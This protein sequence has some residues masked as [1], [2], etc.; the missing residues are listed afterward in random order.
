MQKAAEYRRIA[1]QCEEIANTISFSP[2]REALLERAKQ[3]LA[4]AEK[5]EAEEAASK[6]KERSQLR[7]RWGEEPSS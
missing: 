6:L 2:E 5:L 7:P 4:M 3:W 1:E